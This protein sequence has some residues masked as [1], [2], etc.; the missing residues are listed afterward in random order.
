MLVVVSVVSNCGS[1]MM[2]GQ[3]P[4]HLTD[5]I[6]NGVHRTVQTCMFWTFSSLVAIDGLFS[7]WITLGFILFFNSSKGWKIDCCV[8]RCSGPRLCTASEMP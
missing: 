4:Q 7:Y 5:C 8:T 6:H 2:T 1:L 3:R